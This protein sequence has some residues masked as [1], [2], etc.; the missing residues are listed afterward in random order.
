MSKSIESRNNAL[1]NTMQIL[2]K[3]MKD[4][5]DAPEFH[6]QL[7]R[8]LILAKLATLWIDQDDLLGI[9]TKILQLMEH[10]NKNK[11]FDYKLAECINYI[12][13]ITTE[14]EQPIFFLN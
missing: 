1:N 8:D 5:E 4:V 10:S 13:N 2:E 3:A 6:K 7:L 12:R 9:G 11:F 14:T